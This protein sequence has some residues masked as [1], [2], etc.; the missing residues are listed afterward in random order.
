[1]TRRLFRRPAVVPPRRPA[2]AVTRRRAAAAA[3]AGLLPLVAACGIQGTDVVEAGGAPT[4]LIAPNPESRMLLY[5]V[6]PDGRSM[7]VAR[8]VGFAVPETTFAPDHPEDSRVPSDG[9]GSG[10][11]I[12]EKAL[13]RWHT[14]N[15]KVL[16][17]LLAGPNEAEAAAGLTTALPHG[18]G[19]PHI[20][21]EKVSG[22]QQ[23]RRL[24]RLRTPFKVTDLPPEAVRQLV[25]TTVYARDRLG[26][27]EVTVTG[28]D[29]SLTPTT[30]EDTP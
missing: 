3:L 7:P 6:G 20:Q 19:V 24:L 13:R 26:L 21:E 10:Y 25:C 4:V 2:A 12:D 22:G 23:G 17:M 1:M 14:A 8:D 11:D 5:F 18:A 16:A 27:A 15:D 28:P 30:C 29:G 9:F